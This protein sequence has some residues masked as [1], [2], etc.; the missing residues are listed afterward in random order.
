MK[1][2][3]A[4]AIMFIGVNAFA[5]TSK[6]LLYCDYIGAT[7]ADDIYVDLYMDHDATTDLYSNLEAGIFLNE[8]DTYPNYLWSMV[9]NYQPGN[10]SA[11]FIMSKNADSLS[12]DFPTLP[13]SGGIANFDIP[14]SAGQI[15]DFNVT[16]KGTYKAKAVDQ[17]FLCYDPST[18][19]QP[20]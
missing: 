8:S 12:F 17:S 10:T 5:Q 19:Q 14:K 1:K 6:V 15:T 16:F 2:M 3:T 18:K 9:V 7:E 11:N 20:Q 13:Q 4:L